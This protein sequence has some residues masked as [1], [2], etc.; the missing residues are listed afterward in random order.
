MDKIENELGDSG[1]PKTF[2]DS[3]QVCQQI[4]NHLF[5]EHVTNLMGD[6]VDSDIFDAQEISL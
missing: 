5:D 2:V 4:K 3:L 6:L 1:L